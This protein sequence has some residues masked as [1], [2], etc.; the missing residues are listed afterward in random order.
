MKKPREPKRPRMDHKVSGIALEETALKEAAAKESLESL[1]AEQAEQEAAVKK[2]VYTDEMR[3]ITLPGMDMEADAASEPEDPEDGQESFRD[4]EGPNLKD[5]DEMF[6]IPIHRE[7]KSAEPEEHETESES[8]I[9]M[10]SPEPV[11][12]KPQSRPRGRSLQSE[13]S[14]RYLRY[15]PQSLRTRFR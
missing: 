14:N 15:I 6:R 1:E 3:E 10:E 13:T 4:M 2:E 9:Q 8:V 7:R 5:L 12:R 11:R